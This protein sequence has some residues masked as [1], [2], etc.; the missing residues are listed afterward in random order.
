MDKIKNK[1]KVEVEF[2][3]RM[4]SAETVE[5]VVTPIKLEIECEKPCAFTLEN[6]KLKFVFKVKNLSEI[7]LHNVMFK[8]FLDKQTEFVRDSF[9]VNG[10]HHKVCV[11]EHVLEAEIRELK[12]CQTVT[13]SFEVKTKD[14]KTNC[15]HHDN[16]RDEDR[17]EGDRGNA[18]ACSCECGHRNFVHPS[19]I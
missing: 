9:K 16:D 2:C 10:H 19:S 12:A 5:T 17:D 3:G 11:R 8:D 13:I 1:A 7:E 18:R 15:R 4:H 14:F 6:E